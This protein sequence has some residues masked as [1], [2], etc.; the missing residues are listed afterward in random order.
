MERLIQSI[1][2]HSDLYRSKVLSA[3]ETHECKRRLVD[4]I[5]CGLAAFS[6]PPVKSARDLA[7]KYQLKSQ[8]DFPNILGDSLNV[9]IEMAAFANAF[10]VRYFDGADTFPGGGGHPSDCWAGLIALAQ[11]ED[12]DFETLFKSVMLAYDV[13]YELFTNANL[14]E[15]G[16]DNTFYVTVSTAIGAAFLLHLDSMQFANAISLSIVPNVSLGVARTGRLSMWK[17]GA[18]ANAARNGLFAALLAKEGVTAPELPFSGER[19]LFSISSSFDLNFDQAIKKP[20]IFEAH[21]KRYLCDYHSQVPIDVAIEL[22]SKINVSEVDKVEVLTY[23]F[24]WSEVASDPSKWQ[25]KNRETADHS[26]PW[27]VSAVLIDG[28]F[29]ESIFSS[30]RFDDPEVIQLCSRLEVKEDPK[31]TQQFPS[32]MPCK[33]KVFMK[34]GSVVEATSDL[35]QGHPELPIE[36]ADLERKF[37]TLAQKS[38]SF[39]KAQKFLDKLL[40]TG[41]EE[42]TTGLFEH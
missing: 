4:V 8:C 12:R 11:Q 32:R 39:V 34:N 2:T 1:V 40:S 26:L 16:I 3:L 42:S 31:L 9:S 13:F 38:I 30:D 35:P 22:H 5:A 6:E 33:I 15:S 17:A 24:A 23:W 20:R 25:P 41:L 29:S 14:R 19:G 36:D 28:V 27:I 37:L 10:G 18:S 7:L 21:M